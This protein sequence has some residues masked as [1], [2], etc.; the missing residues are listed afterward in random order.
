MHGT[1]NSEDFWEDVYD[2]PMA[3]FLRQYEQWACTQN[4]NLNERDSLE[5]VRKQA[6]KLIVRGLVAMTGKRDITMNYNN[7]ETAIIETYAV[8][9][10]GWPQGIKFT[11]PSN[12]GTVGEIRKLRDALKDQTCYWAALTP[13]E[14]KVHSAELDARRSAG[15]VVRQPRKKRSD[16]GITRKRKAPPTTGQAHKENRRPSKKVKKNT[17]AQHREAPKSA[18]FIESSDEEEDEGE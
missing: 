18:E 15:Q 6:R 4:Q 11:S 9:L 13:A 5:T 12:I 8:K 3:D 14:V 10:V 16:A 1:D 17:S 7:Y 2:S